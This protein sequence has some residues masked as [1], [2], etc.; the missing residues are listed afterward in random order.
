MR[1]RLLLPVFIPVGVALMIFLLIMSAGKI[2]LEI[3]PKYATAVAIVGALAILFVS[4][5]VASGPPIPRTQLYLLTSLPV[6]VV[7]ATG[8]YLTVRP[9]ETTL[10]GE[11]GAGAGTTVATQLSETATDNKFS[12]AAFTV[13]ANT[14]IT[15]SFENRGQALHNWNLLNVKDKD[16]KNVATQLLTGG[17][18]ETL[19]FTIDKPGTYDFQC[20]VHPTEMKGKLTVT[21]ATAA[22]GQATTG[23]PAGGNAIVATDNKFNVATV[24]IKANEPTTVNF[25]NKGSAVH[26]WHVLNV[27]DKDG[28]DVATK[29]LPGGQAETITFVIDKPGTYDFQCDAHPTEMKGKLTVQ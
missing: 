26:N 29:L 4:T 18:N 17:K 14:E 8:L 23:G 3:D 24:T 25:Q 27:K 9:A 22:T 15:M 28:K 1:E 6:A 21:E 20:D 12:E 19:K 7:I 13:P 16:G 2:L 5:L 11:A 10:V